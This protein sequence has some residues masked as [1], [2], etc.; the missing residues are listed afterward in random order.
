MKLAKLFGSKT[1]TDILKY[2]VFRRQGISIRAFESEL[3]RSFPA[4]KK[5]IDLLEDAW[6]IEIDKDQNK[7]SIY[8]IEWI[9]AH[10][11]GFFV[12]TLQSDLQQ[13]FLQHE[14]L[15]NK[16]FYGKLFGTELDMD[17]VLVYKAE[18]QQHLPKIKE[19]INVIFRKYLIELVN[20][21]FMSASDFDKRYR[22]ADKFVL[23]LMRQTKT[24]GV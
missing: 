17:L 15:I 5:Q 9:G 14:L 11:R 21:V 22:L 10:I 12:Y 23:N 18:A 20:V 24:S 2:L 16:Y 1:K 3:K 4:I 7:W 13:Y 8:L 19:D 6:I